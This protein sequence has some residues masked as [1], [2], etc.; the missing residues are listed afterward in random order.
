MIIC[1]MTGCF[2]SLLIET[3]TTIDGDIK[4]EFRVGQ[5]AR[6]IDSAVD[7]DVVFDKEEFIKLFNEDSQYDPNYYKNHLDKCDLKINTEEQPEEW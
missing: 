4:C 1:L 3:L 2:V 6:F 7:T 5:N